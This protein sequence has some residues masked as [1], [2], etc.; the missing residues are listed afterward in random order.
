MTDTKP[1]TC[2]NLVER[3]LTGRIEQLAEMYETLEAAHTSGDDDALDAAQEAINNFPL[4]VTAKTTLV[5]QISTGGPG[6]EIEVEI[7]KV[8]HSWERAD[9]HVT[10]RYLDWF[11]GAETRT[12]DETILAYVDGIIECWYPEG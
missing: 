6:D 4:C 1:L 7:E 12:A 3:Q 11:D 5:I 2:Q 10:Y 8:S 9:T